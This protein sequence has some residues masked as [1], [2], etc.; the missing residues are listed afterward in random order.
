MKL[1]RMDKRELECKLEPQTIEDLWYLTRLIEEGDIAGGRSWRRFKSQG[2]EGR[3]ESGEKKPVYVEV[4]VENTEFAQA[5]N[6]LRITGKIVAG[7]P[8]EFVS[9]G[10]HHT[11]DIEPG[12][13]VKL[14]KKEF[15]PY[16]MRTLEESRK[17]GARVDALIVAMDEEKALFARL[18]NIGLTFGAEFHTEASKR[19]PKTFDDLQKKYYSDILKAIQITGA[20]KTIIAGP[21]FA[22]DALRKYARDKYSDLM[23]KI[24]FEHAD[25][26]ER[27]AITSMLKA[28]VLEKILGEQKLQDEFRALEALKK[29]LGRSDGLSC[30]GLEKVEIA[31]NAG[32]TSD[33]FV[34]DELLRKGPLAKKVNDLIE[35]ANQ[36]GAKLLI[37]N[38]DDDAGSEFKAFKIAAML[39]YKFQTE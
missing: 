23:A 31:I 7:S 36:M 20:Q 30:Y 11:L 33:V 8:E 21:G 3:A 22:P 19:D 37:F 5:V 9:K 2:G 26:A 38:A 35:K 29:S 6:K 13:A 25:S 34:L 4:K 39:R 28:G 27:T 15:S 12:D 14:R 18:T 24:E 32:A 17:R 10:E 16:F 1:V